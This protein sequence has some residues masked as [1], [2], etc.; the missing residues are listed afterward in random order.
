MPTKA[1][2]LAEAEEAGIEVPEGAIKADIEALLDANDPDR[3][4]VPDDGNVP[5]NDTDARLTRLE[6]TMTHLLRNELSM[7][8]EAFGVER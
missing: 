1:E 8:S 7:A 4:N 2:L 5:D 6:T 3:G